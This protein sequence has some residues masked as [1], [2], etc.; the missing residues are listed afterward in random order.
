MTLEYDMYVLPDRV[1]KWIAGGKKAQVSHL[2]DGITNMQ[3]GK[4]LL[5]SNVAN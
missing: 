5:Y 1:L 4:K 3:T 2:L